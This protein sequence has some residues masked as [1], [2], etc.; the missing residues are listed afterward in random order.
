MRNFK[1]VALMAAMG[2]ILACNFPMLSPTTQPS[3]PT[4]TSAGVA[5]LDTPTTLPPT[6]TAVPSITPTATIV[7]TPS[8]PQVSPVTAA[9]NC[10]SGPDVSYPAASSV[11]LGQ[12]AQ[13]VGRNDDLSWWYVRDPYNTSS[14]CWVSAAVVSTAGNL[15]GLPV[16]APPAAVVTKVTANADVASP[17]VCGG[18]NVIS[19]SGQVT[20]NG[21]TKVQ[22]Q[23]EITGDKNNT[24]PSQTM[25]F[26]GAGTKSAPDPGAYTADCGHYTI[27]LHVTSPNDISASKNFSV[28]P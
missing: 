25:N 24:T 7:P 1:L 23:W 2:L 5:P 20:T 11:A 21:A 18:P 13:I 17:V 8:V 4:P 19:F 15:A 6:F 22:V 28:E 16:I 27:T 10:R 14:F 12:V 26:K 9:V 3:S